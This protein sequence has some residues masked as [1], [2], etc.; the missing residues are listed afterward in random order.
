MYTMK[1]KNTLITW[2]SLQ[3]LCMACDTPTTNAMIPQD[4]IYVPNK[5]WNDSNYLVEGGL[6]SKKELNYKVK[7]N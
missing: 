1:K 7:K 3:G 6:K 2:Q 5:A 4:L